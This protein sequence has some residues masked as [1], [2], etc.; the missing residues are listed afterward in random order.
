MS[1]T[2]SSSAPRPLTPPAGWLGTLTP[3]R[4][5]RVVA[6]HNLWPYFARRFE[7]QVVGFLEPVPGITPTSRHL[8]ELA[9]RMKQDEI[10]VILSSAYFHPRYARKLAKVSGAVV[11]EMANQVG[12]RDG[13]EDY[14][15]M[16]EWNVSELSRALAR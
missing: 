2:H 16:C 12:A 14:L 4:G 11:V 1:S 8:T 10:S 13:V 6:D 5:R 7:V 9:R 15:G 3:E